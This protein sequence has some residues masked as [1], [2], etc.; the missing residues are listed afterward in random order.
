MRPHSLTIGTKLDCLQSSL[1]RQSLSL[2]AHR[3]G[4]PQ[5]QLEQQLGPVRR[6]KGGEL[7]SAQ[8]IDGFQFVATAKGWVIPNIEILYRVAPRSTKTE[9]NIQ[10]AKTSF[11]PADR[12]TLVY[13][14]GVPLDH[15]TM[16]EAI[17]KL[18]A[19]KSSNP[20]AAIVITYIDNNG[21]IRREEYPVARVSLSED[22]SATL[23][24]RIT[25]T[26]KKP[27]YN[28]KGQTVFLTRPLNQDP[29]AIKI[30]PKITVA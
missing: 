7:R 27:Y 26:E 21:E 19:I 17:D 16:Q 25:I 14:T 20:K 11:K 22:P 15:S 24:I 13:S 1:V 30:T 6:T 28:E 4:I 9:R 3:L 10:V 18:E 8:T 29:K 2:A 5:S 23:G 12:D